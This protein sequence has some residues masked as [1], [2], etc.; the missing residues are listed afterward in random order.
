MSVS[1]AINLGY[2]M[3]D[4]PIYSVLSKNGYEVKAFLIEDFGWHWPTLH[5]PDILNFIF[6]QEKEDP[7]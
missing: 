3:H 6:Q 1:E 7:K 2:C 5:H 4:E